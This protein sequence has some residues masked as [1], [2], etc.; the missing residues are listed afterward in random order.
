[1]LTA[2]QVDASEDMTD[3]EFDSLVRADAEH[4]VAER[5]ARADAEEDAT[6]AAWLWEQEYLDERVELC[7]CMR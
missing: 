6:L 7:T 3:D 1:M 4:C 2:E 5:R